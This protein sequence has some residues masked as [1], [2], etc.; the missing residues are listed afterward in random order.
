MGV[1]GKFPELDIFFHIEDGKLLSLHMCVCVRERMSVCVCVRDRK[2][3]C[4]CFRERE[5]ERECVCV[6]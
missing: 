5:R 1:G 6:C 4:V 2:K 3:V